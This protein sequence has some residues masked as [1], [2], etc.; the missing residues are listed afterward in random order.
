MNE[1]SAWAQ[2]MRKKPLKEEMVSHLSASDVT[3]V[4]SLVTNNLVVRV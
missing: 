3:H 4:T 1:Q 2:V